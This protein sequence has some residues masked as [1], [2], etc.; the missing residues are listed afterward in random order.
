MRGY[1][2]KPLPPPQEEL[3][4]DFTEAV[5]SNGNLVPG[6]AMVLDS[7]TTEQRIGTLLRAVEAEGTIATMP[8]AALWVC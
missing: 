7:T 2:F 5:K 8:P 1:F 6:V 3:L 4:K